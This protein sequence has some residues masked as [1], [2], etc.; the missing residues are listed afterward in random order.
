MIKRWKKQTQ[1]NKNLKTTYFWGPGGVPLSK[2]IYIYAF[3]LTHRSWLPQYFS[4]VMPI[5]ADISSEGLR[6]LPGRIVA[7]C[8]CFYIELFDFLDVAVIPSPWYDTS[9]QG[10]E[11]LPI[12]CYFAALPAFT[13]GCRQFRDDASALNLG[14]VSSSCVLNKSTKNDRYI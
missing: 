3:V 10:R 9:P 13:R 7:I 5:S 12:R 6:R 8:F 1:S 4:V 14:N 11:L 2:Y